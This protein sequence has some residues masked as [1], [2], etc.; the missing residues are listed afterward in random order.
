[1]RK[2]KNETAEALEIKRGLISGGKIL[3]NLLNLYIERFI[4]MNVRT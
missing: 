1:M 2:L 4:I 3:K